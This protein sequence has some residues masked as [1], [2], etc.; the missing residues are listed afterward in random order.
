MNRKETAERIKIMQALVDGK[1]IEFTVS[2]E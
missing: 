2:K 1:Q